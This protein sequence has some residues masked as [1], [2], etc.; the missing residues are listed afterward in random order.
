MVIKA[1]P[2]PI[3]AEEKG[4]N[5]HTINLNNSLQIFFKDALRVTVR[6]PL[7][8]YH[9]FKTI[10]WQQKAAK[11]RSTWKKQG[12]HVPP[13]IIF[14]ITERC[15]LKCKGC[16]AQTLH[17]VPETE[18]SE[19]EL[20]K[21]IAQAHE[22][23]NSFFVLAGGE[24]LVRHEILDITR[25]FPEM[26]FLIFTNGMLIDEEIV[27]TLKRQ[28]NVVPVISLEGYE[29]ETDD[30]RGKGVYKHLKKTVEKIKSKGIFWAVS[31]TITSSNF[32]TVTDECFIKDMAAMPHL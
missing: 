13:I 22:L 12:I 17:R 15:N 29:E 14:S 6:N 2:T 9:C 7:Q 18:L 31:L 24:P 26:L 11:V 20:I 21:F 16:Y 23:G 3:V 28:K 8:A 19:D 10:R 30:R 4:D 1:P 32:E 27:K 5:N 25:K